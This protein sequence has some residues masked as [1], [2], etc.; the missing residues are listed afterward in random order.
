MQLSTTVFDNVQWFRV[1]IYLVVGPLL[2]GQICSHMKLRYAWAG[3]YT[4]KINHLG[5]MLV[6]API[7]AVLPDAQ[8]LPSVLV[9][10]AAQVCIYVAAAHSEQ[11]ILHAV[12]LHSLRATDEPR[13]RLFFLL[14]M[15]S[16]NVALGISVLLYPMTLVKIAFFTV[17]LGDGLAEPAGLL[18]GKGNRF[19]V[20]D[21]L[22]NGRNTK[23]IAGCLTV[24]AFAF[25]TALLLLGVQ[26]AVTPTLV[27]LCAAYAIVSVALEALSPRG[28]DNMV[29]IIFS[30]LA[31]QGLMRLL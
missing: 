7:L 1:A 10:S 19:Q 4:R 13:S 14:P 3:G 2:I 30:P 23:S 9:A 22:W 17:A 12:A 27:V 21:W 20:R 6:T 16:F 5:I 31:I 28:L 18:F 29:L 24:L 8:L 15:I 25:L 11:P 26:Q